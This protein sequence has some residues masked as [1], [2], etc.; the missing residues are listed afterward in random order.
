MLYINTRAY[1]KY[2]I[3][4]MK[5]KTEC[6]FHTQLINYLD[7]QIKLAMPFQLAFGQ[8]HTHA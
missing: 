5:Q 2:F 3:S 4:E 8:F 1:A 7:I 6:T